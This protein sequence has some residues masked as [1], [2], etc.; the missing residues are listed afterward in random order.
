[1]SAVRIVCIFA[2]SASRSEL[3]SVPSKVIVNSVDINNQTD[4]LYHEEKHHTDPVPH[5][6]F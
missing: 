4:R 2:S 1:M 5:P 6:V 3:S